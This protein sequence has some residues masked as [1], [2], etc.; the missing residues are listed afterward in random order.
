M[1]AIPAPHLEV[2]VLVLGMAI[3]ILE[4]F[5]VKID[6]KIFAYAGIVGLAVVL[7][8]SFFVASL[9]SAQYVRVTWRFAQAVLE[10]TLA[11]K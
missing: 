3:L 7:I 9:K 8:A 4:T 10:K 5:A 2:D 11:R 6:R 1:I